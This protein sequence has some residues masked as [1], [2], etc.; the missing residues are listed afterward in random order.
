MS[1]T[2]VRTSEN[3]NNL[4]YIKP[5]KIDFEVEGH[6]VEWETFEIKDSVYILIFNKN[7]KS[8]VFVKQ[9]RAVVYTSQYFKKEGKVYGSLSSDKMPYDKG[10]TLELCA[11]LCD[12]PELTPQQAAAE[13]VLEETGYKVSADDL[14]LITFFLSGARVGTDYVYFVE[15]SDDQKVSNGGGLLNEGESITVEERPAKSFAEAVIDDSSSQCSGNIVLKFACLWFLQK[16][17]DF[18]VS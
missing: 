5:I 12:K 14:T 2:N 6:P 15:V 17:K 8:F 4:K 18:D 10:L 3:P 16:Y 13:E 11:G 7:R 1:I 9:F